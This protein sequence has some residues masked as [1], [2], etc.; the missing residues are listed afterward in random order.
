MQVQICFSFF[1]YYFVSS[2]SGQTRSQKLDYDQEV[3]EKLMEELIKDLL[4]SDFKRDQN[5]SDFEVG[6]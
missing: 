1:L 4:D 2:I 5:S 3:K 6:S